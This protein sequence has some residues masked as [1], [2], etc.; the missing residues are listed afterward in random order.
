MQIL[1]LRPTY[2]L[3]RGR[4]RNG[5]NSE[6]DSAKRPALL[7]ESEIQF[8][9]IVRRHNNQAGNCTTVVQFNLL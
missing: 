7:F 4:P 2:P 3:S 9:L 1:S 8:R 5:I 6:K